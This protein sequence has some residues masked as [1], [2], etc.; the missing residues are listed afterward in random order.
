M[1]H[2]ATRVS[3]FLPKRMALGLLVA[4]AGLDGCDSSTPTQPESPAA[5]PANIEAS[6]AATTTVFATGFEFP[7]G[8]TW[9]PD[10]KM[11]VAEAGSGGPHTI[12]NCRQVVGPVGPYTGGNTARISRVDAQGKRSTFATGFPSGANAFGDVVGVADLAV[13]GQTMYA[14][15]AGGGCSH[16]SGKPAQIARLF[17]SGSWS[18]V[19]NLSAFQRSHPVAHPFAGDFEPD[20]TWY[21]MVALNGRLFAVEPNHGEIARINPLTGRDRPAHRHLGESGAYRADSHH[22][23]RRC[24][25]RHPARDI[26][27]DT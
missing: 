24:V 8:F 18:F 26:P 23:P 3:A 11:Y 1:T 19:T 2:S 15:V 4:A 6:A 14:L 12:S 5:V 25:L 13:V 27:R 22:G 17:G 9:G 10:G 16:G 20:G 7:R 21:S